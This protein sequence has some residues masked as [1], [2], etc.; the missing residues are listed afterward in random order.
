VIAG[1]GIAPQ[2]AFIGAAIPIEMRPVGVEYFDDL[3][4]VV[5]II[6]DNAVIA[7]QREVLSMRLK[8]ATNAAFSSTTIDFSCVT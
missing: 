8:V 6:G 7:G 4:D 2:Q 5:G 3:R 1:I